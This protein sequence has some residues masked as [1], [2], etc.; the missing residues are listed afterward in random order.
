M[1]MQLALKFSY[2][3]KK[4]K[5]TRRKIWRYKHADLNGA[6]D[7]LLDVDLESIINPYDIQSTWSNWKKIFLDI[8]DECIPTSILPNR[9]NL[10]WLTKLGHNPTNT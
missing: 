1:H 4:K 10:P 5:K 3:K 7:L 8:M 2:K 9:K 6:N